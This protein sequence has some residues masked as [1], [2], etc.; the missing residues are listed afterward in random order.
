MVFPAL[1]LAAAFFALA[2]PPFAP[3]FF[4]ADF[5]AAFLT[6]IFFAA[7]FFAGTFFA[8]LT[9]AFLATFFT[10]AFFRRGFLY[11]RCSGFFNDYDYGFFH[12]ALVIV[13]GSEHAGGFDLFVLIVEVVV[14][15]GVQFKRL[16]CG[17]AVTH[18]IHPEHFF[19]SHCLQR[20][21]ADIELIFAFAQQAENV[22]LAEA[23]VSIACMES[24]TKTQARNA[25]R[26][27]FLS[28]R[29]RFLVCGLLVRVFFPGA[30]GCAGCWIGVRVR[31]GR[32]SS[33]GHGL[34][35][36]RGDR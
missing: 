8:A 9:G 1:F 19:R 12:N 2:F 7:A 13:R 10:G 29:R 18:G 23:I 20:L 27:E 34:P 35:F 36:R 26:A 14:V 28:L 15:V 33:P 4:A 17:V 3:A 6:T 32:G 22:L 21:A 16:A 5:F 25:T 30:R 31:L 11:G 24:A